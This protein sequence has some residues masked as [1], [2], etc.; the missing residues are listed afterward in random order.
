MKFF[1][2]FRK[3]KPSLQDDIAK[4]IQWIVEALNSSDYKADYSLESLKE[5]DRFLE[6]EQRPGGI[7]EQNRGAILFA[8]GCYVGDVIRQ[9]TGGTWLTNDKDPMGEVN[10]TLQLPSG[11]VIWPVQRVISRYKIGEDES[12]HTY[13]V[14]IVRGEQKAG[15]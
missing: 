2:R 14:V 11:T 13:A 5:I 8:L 4:G 3:K 15:S 10:I 7:L 12:I 6:K 1:D 9:Q